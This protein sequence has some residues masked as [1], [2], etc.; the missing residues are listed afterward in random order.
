MSP[1]QRELMIRVGDL[2][3]HLE[4]KL[5]RDPPQEPRAVADLMYLVE[6]E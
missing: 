2:P 1:Y 6:L 3:A 4:L 5:W